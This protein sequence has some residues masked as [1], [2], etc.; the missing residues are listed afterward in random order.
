MSVFK[1]ANTQL[2]IV[3]CLFLTTTLLASNS[4][5]SAPK[6]EVKPNKKELYSLVKQLD[7]QT[8]QLHQNFFQQEVNLVD[9]NDSIGKAKLATV[10]NGILDL[11]GELKRLSFSAAEMTLLNRKEKF[12]ETAASVDKYIA[13]LKKYEKRINKIKPLIYKNHQPTINEIKDFLK[14]H[15]TQLLQN[16]L[17]K[18]KAI[19]AIR[20]VV[21]NS[22]EVMAAEIGRCENN[23]TTTAAV[24]KT[25]WNNEICKMS[26]FC[27]SKL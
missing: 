8:Y 4:N 24:K 5:F 6:K 23:W 11:Q 15:R 27:N 17:L 18:D 21:D 3:S 2:I 12:P 14:I 13:E 16:P 26:N 19:L 25:G 9:V 10:I 7:R 22:R 1:R 20:Q